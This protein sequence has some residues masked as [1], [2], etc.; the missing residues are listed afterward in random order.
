MKQLADLHGLGTFVPVRFGLSTVHNG[1]GCVASVTFDLH[2]RGIASG[3]V[4]V[5]NKTVLC[6]EF[7]LCGV[8]LQ[9][10]MV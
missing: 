1:T 10:V 9:S 5:W 6:S 3:E 8:S 2:H 4:A 7:S